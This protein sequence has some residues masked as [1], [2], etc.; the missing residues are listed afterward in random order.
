MK[1]K[2]ETILFLGTSRIQIPAIQSAKNLNYK[3]IGVD[4]NKFS[5][6]KKLCDYFF[7]FDSNN[8]D[9]IYKKIKKIK[10]IK[11]VSIWA[12]NDILLISKSLLEKKLKIKSL[13]ISTSKIKLLLNKSKFKSFIKN[14]PLVIKETG[15][16][17]FPIIAKLSKGS[18]SRGIKLIYNNN[19]LK[20]VD[21]KKFVFENYIKNGNEYGINFY[22]T[23]KKIFHLPGVKRF[24]Y[25]K[26]T[27]SPLGTMTNKKIRNINTINR[28]LID[29]IK[30]LK[31]YGQIKF[32]LII[33]SNIPKIFE[34]SPRFHGEID[35]THLFNYTNSNLAKFYFERLSNNN[36][37]AKFKKNINNY[38]YVCIYN[39]KVS[40]KIILKYFKKFDLK[41]KK[42]LK[43]DNYTKKKISL[44]LSTNDIF[45]YAFFETK[46]YLSKSK[47]IKL[48]KHINRF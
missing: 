18:G 35:T 6:G 9:L 15:K 24:F 36:L 39:D 12:N 26:I 2:N 8:I 27:F 37:P 4:K 10:N 11:I 33:N 40:K 34:L 14:S 23:K 45:S 7:N 29:I 32:D 16:Y 31:L 5:S 47:F 48:S 19:Q 38:G 28:L 44:P 21:Q 17:K 30:K 22:R 42:L 3:I 20:K 1:N 25:H 43:R 13:N 46:N 41:F